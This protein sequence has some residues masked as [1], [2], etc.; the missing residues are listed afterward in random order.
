VVR[1]NIGARAESV[2]VRTLEGR[3]V[4]VEADR[5]VVCSGGIEAPRLLLASGLGDRLAWTGKGFHDHVS[6]IC[7]EIVPNDRKEFDEIF[8]NWH[9]EGGKLMPKLLL[10][11]QKQESEKLV[12]VGGHMVFGASGG[13]EALKGL[14]K[15]KS[16]KDATPF[17]GQALKSFPEA[18]AAAVAAGIKGRSYAP[19]NSK[20][21]FE[22]L[23]EQTPH[24][25]SEIRLS[26]RKDEFGMPLPV[27]DFKIG[28]ETQDSIKVLMQTVSEQ[29]K[30][31]AETR[32]YEDRLNSQREFH[33]WAGD[34]YHPMGATR[35]SAAPD[36]GVVDENLKV[37]GVDNLFVASTS[38]FPSGGWSNPTYA[39]LA[40]TCRLADQ[41]KN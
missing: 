32:I 31:L 38:C 9:S 3:E 39:M 28:E 22:A 34:I 41:I 15:A 18:A 30:G 27:I 12:E 11:A 5:I 21:E 2:V 33:R 36:D 8:Q 14:R 16:I 4:I 29:L 19:G 40:L 7:A 10:S 26:N 17:A 13:F 35:M 37:H 20:I 25:G 6:I 1:I 24:N 23:C